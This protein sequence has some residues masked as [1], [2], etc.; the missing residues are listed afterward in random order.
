M[1]QTFL[2]TLTP[3]VTLFL[4]MAIGFVLAKTKILPADSSK[5]LAKLETWVFCP[6]L[7][8]MTMAGS[9][10]IP[11]LAEH[12]T[13]LIFSCVLVG[14]VLT[15]GIS[16]APLFV[17]TKCYERCIYQYALAFANLGYMGDPLVQSLFGDDV[18]GAYKLFCLPLSITIYV[19]GISVLTPGS[20]RGIVSSLKRALNLPTL[21]MLA[22]M[23]VG[24][25]GTLGYIPAFAV[26]ALNTLKACMGPV[27]M[28]LAGVIVAKYNVVPLLKIKKVYAATL[29]RLVVLPA[30]ILSLLT[31]IRW[32]FNGLLGQTLSAAPIYFAFFA[33][34]LPLG[35]NTV[36]FPEA[37]GGD[38]EPGASMAIISSTL[39]L[40]SIPIFYTVL[41]ELIACPFAAI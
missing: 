22:G 30:L 34:A 6:A 32:V 4:F 25:T 3:V 20:D 27:A 37:Y 39:S 19:W 13:N 9:F 41:T 26:N 15:I 36:V 14:I 35:M 21:S 17:K 8:F 24:I 11:K 7:S 40:V 16:L 28:L 38:P 29:L 31:G 33:T 5:T 10:T 18:L 23:L 12:G 1:L 2:Y